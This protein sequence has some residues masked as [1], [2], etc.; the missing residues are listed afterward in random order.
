MSPKNSQ[1][2]GIFEMFENVFKL[3]D[4]KLKKSIFK[5]IKPR[6]KKRRP[7]YYN[8][9]I[10]NG[11]K[12]ALFLKQFDKYCLSNGNITLEHLYELKCL[13]DYLGK[14]INTRMISHLL[15]EK[16]SNIMI[17]TDKNAKIREIWNKGEGISIIRLCGDINHFEALSREYALIKAIGLQNLTNQ[18]NGTRYGIMHDWNNELIINFGNMLLYYTLKMIIQSKPNILYESDL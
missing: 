3:F 11:T 15:T 1:L 18:V 17:K 8:Y 9:A 10:C 4:K 16:N 13:I 14:G 2:E 7:L 12:L 6:G 5:Q